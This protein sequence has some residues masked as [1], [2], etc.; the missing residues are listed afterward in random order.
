MDSKP[1]PVQLDLFAKI[2]TEDERQ[3][4]LRERLSS[5]INLSIE[6]VI[7]LVI[8]VTLT[9]L[10]FF[11]LG[12]ERGKRQAI[13]SSPQVITKEAI[14]VPQETTEAD[15]RVSVSVA[16]A[17]LPKI[18]PKAREVELFPQITAS[19][20]SSPVNVA[21]VVSESDKNKPGNKRYTIQ[22]ASFQKDDFAKQEENSLK[23]LGYPTIVRASGH[24]SILCVGSFNDKQEAEGIL[25]RLRSK[26]HDCFI[27]RL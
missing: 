18:I 12:V 10:L 15:S 20:S 3:T 6:N 26:Y 1:K 9:I 8:F 25:R 11:S 4:G 13:S 2:K 14:S 24:F 21:R 23:G 22:V 16:K 19:S 7:V 27:R 5:R 17:A